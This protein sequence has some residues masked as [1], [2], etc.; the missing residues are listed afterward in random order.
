MTLRTT[1]EVHINS[2][3]QFENSFHQFE[4]QVATSAIVSMRRFKRGEKDWAYKIT[5]TTGDTFIAESPDVSILCERPIQIMPA[6]AGTSVCHFGP[7]DWTVY[8]RPVIAWAICADGEVRPVTPAGVND[9]DDSSTQVVVEM[10]DGRCCERCWDGGCY[11]SVDE[12][13]VDRKAWI[14]KWGSKHA[15][16][17]GAPC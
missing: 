14:A 3:H 8:R 13:V 12:Y 10:P 2:F 4:H 9:S 7:D 6:P 16:P 5:L 11:A 1:K 15:A 17:E